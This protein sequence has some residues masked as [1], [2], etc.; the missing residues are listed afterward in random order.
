MLA[1]VASFGWATDPG[2]AT[3]RRAG[4]SPRWPEGTLI[5]ADNGLLNVPPAGVLA[6]AEHPGRGA[7]ARGGAGRRAAPRLAV[8]RRRQPPVAELLPLPALRA[9]R[10]GPT[11]RQAIE[12]LTLVGLRQRPGLRR[13]AT[14]SMALVARGELADAARCI[15]AAAP[16]RSTRRGGRALLA[17]G[18]ACS[19]S[20]PRRR[21]DE[22]LALAERLERDF[23]HVRN[24]VAARG[25]SP[26]GGAPPRRR[27]RGRLADLDEQLEL[28]RPWGAPGA[29][30]RGAACPRRALRRRAALDPALGAPRGLGHRPRRARAGAAGPRPPAAARPRAHRGPRAAAPRARG[31]GHVRRRRA[32]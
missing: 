11:A 9:R 1:A 17:P 27:R 13:G 31:R 3:L 25:A 24:P 6:Y 12:E 14:S 5:E 15:G 21:D 16:S 23:G 19:C 26:G 4:R 28:A 10:G 22:A 2:P 20:S 8:R 32:H 18:R 29:D 7:D 30:R